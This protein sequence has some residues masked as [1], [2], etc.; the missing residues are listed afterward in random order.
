[1]SSLTRPLTDDELSAAGI[2]PAP[3]AH[4]T[5]TQV[6]AVQDGELEIVTEDTGNDEAPPEP[7][8]IGPAVWAWGITFGAAIGTLAY[9]AAVTS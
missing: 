6:F 2:E 5:F 7:T 3:I 1:M 9:A 8:R 4:E